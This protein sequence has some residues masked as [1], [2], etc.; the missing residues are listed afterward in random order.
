MDSNRISYLFNQL[1]SNSLS[2]E[3]REELYS[4]LRSFENNDEILAW[5]E[6]SYKNTTPQPINTEHWRPIL[7]SVLSHREAKIV[8]LKIRR[9]W[10]KWVAAACIILVTGYVLWVTSGKPRNGSPKTEVA[11]TH[12]L[13]APKETRA[14]ITLA[15]GQKVYLDSVENG[16]IATETGVNVV[17]TEDGKIAYKP[18]TLSGVE[19]STVTY[20]SLSNPR[21]SKVI[22]LT[23][24]DGTRVWLNAES[25]L[26]YPT[27]FTANTREVEIT[28]EAYFE[29]KHNAKQPFK[30]HLPNGSVVEDIGTSFNIN[31]YSDEDNIRTT[32]IEGSVRV[33]PLSPAGGGELSASPDRKRP[34]VDR[35]VILKPGQ[36]AELTRNSQLITHNSPDLEEVMAWKNGKFSY[37][38]TDLPTI[39]RQM[40]RWYDVEVIYQDPINDRYTVDIPRTVPVSQLFKFI[41]MSGGVHFKI[42]G[43]RITVTK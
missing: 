32:L 6:D 12:D 41:E 15:N 35:G 18:V 34:G 2:T 22:S 19:A 43:K 8:P 3:E 26:K 20:N 31:T 28:G 39:M 7:E 36:Q 21:G 1:E 23:L 27:A 13:S 4:L 37:S 40:A 5:L 24:S 33:T 25:S 38:N 16:T 29:V 11:Q 30:V 42:E 10:I 17:K 14:V 9:T